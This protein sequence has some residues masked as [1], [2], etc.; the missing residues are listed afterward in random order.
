M[1]GA[2]M[3]FRVAVLASGEG[4]NLQAIVDQLHLQDGIEVACVGSNRAGARALERARAAGIDTAIFSA[5]DFGDRSVRDT[6]LAD[7]LDAY[8]VQLV[9]LAGYMEL[10]SPEFVH[11]FEGS[12]INVHPSLLPAFPGVGAIEKALAHGVRV[13][14]VT[15]HFVD[16]GIDSGPI[17]LQEA[18]PVSEPASIETVTAEIHAVEHRLLPQAIRLMAKGAVQIATDN[19]RQVLIRAAEH[20]RV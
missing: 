17:I 18:V 2:A 15:V 4:S 1:V 12:V 14:G 13:T 8:E 11:R 19:P 16:E 20:G 9:V 7:W 10:L 6:A 3:S 5:R